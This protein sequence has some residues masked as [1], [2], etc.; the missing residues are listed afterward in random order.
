MK[1]TPLVCRVFVCLL[2]LSNFFP[3]LNAQTSNPPER[4]IPGRILVQFQPQVSGA[5]ANS[6]VAAAGGR[7]V[8][9]LD[10]IGV[11]VVALP[12]GANET[13]FARAFGQRPEVAFAEVDRLLPP[14]AVTPNDPYYANQWHLGRIEAPAAWSTTTGHT[15]VTIAILDT[16]VDPNH[17]DLSSKLVAGWNFYDNNSNT[18][19]VY[20]HGTK[21]AGTA[22]AASNNGVGV[23]SVAWNC[24]IMPIRISQ[25]DGWATYSAMANGLTWAADR[26]ARVANISYAASNSS[27]VR[28]A[29]QYFYNKGG[30]V[31]MSA[32]NNSYFDPS[33]DNPYVLT[34]SGSDPNDNLYSWSNTG[35]NVDLAAPGCVGATTGNGGGYY[36]ACG[37]SFSAP[38]VAGVAALVLSV[39]PSASGAE[40]T[41]ILKQ[42]ADDRGA[43][44]W[45]PSFGW[46]RVNAA[47]A[48]SMA[49]GTPGDTQAPS[50]SFLAPA[51]GA[52]VSG[53][54]TIDI[55]ASDNVGVA[56]VAVAVDGVTLETDSTSPYSF[57]W[58]TAN[59]ANGVHTLTA[60]AGDA[61][62]N[63]STAT[64][65]VTV[66]NVS[67]SDT[68]P[69]TIA[70]I[71]PASGS[72]VSGNVSVLVNTSDNVRVV[73]VELYVDGMLT[74]TSTTAPFTTK[75]NT[76]KATAGP[77]TLLS[78]AY[79]AAGNV[80]LSPA[81]SVTK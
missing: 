76:R 73:K 47:R 23:A 75:W 14:G 27:T 45:D 49:G 58:N 9:A 61:A 65:T 5:E 6:L 78:K 52:T 7:V 55:A 53:T 72:R 68:T 3:L 16:G 10:R 12:A 80:G 36:T 60:T 13:A 2:Y 42:S 41:D 43:S 20:G 15:S 19:D 59:V 31:T 57:S 66:N 37:T 71:S 70:I 67:A 25:P 79:D 62:G 28:S 48:V 32:G 39:K 69:P 46:G 64:I 50:V 21:V 34:V 77:H 74:A 22:A 29:A 51:P 24:W 30:V 63:T 17:E 81:V 35:N 18:S 38:L 44:G 40:L 56:S 11:R 1:L 26:G 4:I 8:E 33:A 54:I